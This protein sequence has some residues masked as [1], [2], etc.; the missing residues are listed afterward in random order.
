[1]SCVVRSSAYAWRRNEKGPAHI[2]GAFGF[3]SEERQFFATSGF[4]LSGAQILKL[5]RPQTSQP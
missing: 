4:G 1:M 2:R 5:M 3:Y